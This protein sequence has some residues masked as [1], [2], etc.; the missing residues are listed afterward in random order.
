MPPALMNIGWRVF[1]GVRYHDSRRCFASTAI[2]SY[3]TNNQP[4]CLL[5]GLHVYRPTCRG[6]L[7]NKTVKAWNKMPHLDEHIVVDFIWLCRIILNNIIFGLVI[8]YKG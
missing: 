2:S 5:Y 4:Q 8:T 1:R 6:D 3:W 7:L